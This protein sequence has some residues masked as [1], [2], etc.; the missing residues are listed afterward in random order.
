MQN[1]GLIRFFAIAFAVVCL[2]QLS[3]TYFSNKV[4][5]DADK[6]ANSQRIENMAERIAGNDELRKMVVLDSL[7]NVYRRFY[8]DS[9]MGETV[10][11]IGVKKYTFAEV[12]ER[13]LNLGLDLRGGMNV[14][15]EIAVSEIV[16]AL[17]GNSQDPTFQTAMENAIQEQRDG[18]RQD[19]V[20]LFGEA[21]QE[22][23]PNASLAAI[24]AT[25][26]MRD[27]IN[28]NSSNEEVLSEIQR[29]VDDAIDRSFQILRTRIDRFGVTQPNIQ[30]LQTSGRI[31][32]ELPGIK[33]QD[34]VRRLLQGTARLEF[35]ET[36][37]FSDVYSYL[38]EANEILAQQSQQDEPT[39]D[40]VNDIETDA[41][42][43]I[44]ELLDDQQTDTLDATEESDTISDEDELLDMLST[45]L[46]EEVQADAEFERE[47]PL[48]AL[49]NPNIS[50]DPQ[51][52]Q[53]FLGNGPVVGSAAIKD[54]LKINSYLRQ[55]NI[56]SLFPRE[57][58]LRW[59]VKPQGETEN[60]L[61][62]IAIKVPTRGEPPLTGEVIV[63][64]RQD[65]SPNGS[66]EISMTMNSEGAREWRRLTAAN[67]GSSIAIVLDDYVYSFP[68]VQNEISG[69]R[70]SI[71]GNFTVAEAQDLANILRAGSLPAPARIVEE[72]IVGPSLGREAIS[73]GLTSFVIAFIIVLI[74]M[75]IYYSRA[76]L[77]SDLA[78]V[79]NIFFIFGVLAS[80]GAVLTLPGIAGIVLTLGMAVD[81]NV[82]IYERI[83]EE[84]R[85]GKG[86]KLA[87]ADGYKNAYSAI[88]DGNVTTLLTGVVLYVFG[89]GPVQGFATTLIIGI[90]SSL[91]TAVFISRLIFS[92]WMDKNIT[93]R[94]DSK[95]SKDV[96][97]K[98]NFDFIGVRKKFYIISTVVILLGLVSFA[99]RG[100]NYGVDFSGGRSYVVRFDQ[101]I[102]T[103]DMR[104]ALM[105]EFGEAPE[106]KTFGPS[107]QVKITTAFLIDD[108]STVADSIAE[109]TLF[110]GIK[111]FFV[112]PVDYSGFVSEEEDKVLG[113]LSSQKVGPT[114]A[115]D[116][117][118]GAIISVLV[119]LV[120]IFLYVAARFKKWQFGV[121]G[122]ITLFHDAIIVL[123]LYSILY[124]IVPWTMEIDQTFIAAILTI[125]GYSV[126]DTVIIFD[127]IRENT[128]LYP[129]RDLK[130]NINNALNATL[131]RTFNT[132][133]TTIAVLLIIFLFGGEVI[134]G[135]AFALMVGIAIGTYSSLFNATP[136]AYDLITMKKNKK[137]GK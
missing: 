63:D 89:S 2:Y 51:S 122:I 19:F 24:F 31:L 82:I 79:T 21:F 28:F 90:L 53:P 84:I 50:M 105:D 137:G 108:E 97:T 15:L 118:R 128:R 6:Y 88:V 41:D 34:R 62:L 46:D 26:E 126:N 14:T 61:Q 114:V 113:R 29:Q 120:I 11:N 101:D 18:S 38:D 106:V 35:W 83:L 32:I 135:F 1:K 94:F 52:Q 17:A 23:D 58:R 56:R 86:Q 71:T 81:A 127:R 87:V 91:F 134:R 73:S 10:L 69:G 92:A 12:K 70:S 119:A 67:I 3:F 102:N 43:A 130:L 109:R 117:K 85:A 48:F 7:T 66:A 60:I 4:E 65:F 123:S 98:V 45:D 104:T 129:K 116:I 30:Q 100:L 16:R 36:Y 44:E 37:E 111:D 25:P 9:M 57:L 80:L 55:P 132:S 124:N 22:A 5:N 49:L 59:T 54:T 131:S 136:I 78:L 40:T 68:T 76:G 13:E 99:L 95:I 42:D 103:V 47:N 74:Y 27:R 77:V 64:A 115:S 72:A 110:E 96:L 125:I 121:G 93:I 107:N 39:T 133:G 112:E 20:D 8:L 75:A 33:E